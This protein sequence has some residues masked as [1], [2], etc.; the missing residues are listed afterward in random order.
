MLTEC[1]VRSGY[2]GDFTHGQRLDSLEFEDK[3]DKIVFRRSLPHGNIWP[4]LSKITSKMQSADY[5]VTPIITDRDD[6]WMS[7][8]QVVTGHCRSL[9]RSRDRIRKARQLIGETFGPVEI[10]RYDCFA[11]SNEYRGR[12]FDRWRIDPKEITFKDG[13]EKYR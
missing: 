5:I 2:F 13:N 4:D 6:E 10:I 12:C 9:Q 11:K 8:S 3:P 1:F 7:T